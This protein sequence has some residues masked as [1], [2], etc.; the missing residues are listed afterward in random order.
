LI[1]AS[2]LSAAS[3]QVAG[4]PKVGSLVWMPGSVTCAPIG[5]MT[6]Y[7]PGNMRPEPAS[8]SLILI[9]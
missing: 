9:T 7:W 5:S 2:S 6:M 4:N 8:T 3:T 1:A